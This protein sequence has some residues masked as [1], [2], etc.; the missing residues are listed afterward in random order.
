M[1]RAVRDRA[2]LGDLAAGWRSLRVERGR[3]IS[4]SRSI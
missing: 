4:I 1:Q 2:F 3:A